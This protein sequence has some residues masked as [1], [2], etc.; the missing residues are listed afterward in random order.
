MDRRTALASLGAVLGAGVAGCQFGATESE[1][2]FSLR[3]V[4][5]HVTDAGTAIVVGTVEKHGDS[6]GD[7]TI[8][9][10]LQIHDDYDHASVQTFVI[11]ADVDSRAVA[12]PFTSDS[13]FYAEQTFTARAK[14]V[15]HGEGD[16][17][18]VVE[19]P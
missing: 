17:D 14:I 4:R 2:S 7:V 19:E 9:A 6:A 15:R 18:W 12:L 1:P 8:R 5:S 16:G 10:E 3:E 11:E 13:S